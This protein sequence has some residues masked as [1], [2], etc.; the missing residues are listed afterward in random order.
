MTTENV[1]EAIQD[2]IN[3]AYKNPGEYGKPLFSG[4]AAHPNADMELAAKKTFS[5]GRQTL[6]PSLGDKGWMIF[7]VQ[8]VNGPDAKA[9]IDDL[10]AEINLP[11]REKAGLSRFSNYTPK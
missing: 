1:N 11:F 8:A 3:A 2:G 6:D 4:W 9:Q 7:T 5:M 10:V